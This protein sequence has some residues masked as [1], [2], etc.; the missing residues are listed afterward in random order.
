M[1]TDIGC[2]SGWHQIC[3]FSA[4]QKTSNQSDHYLK[5]LIIITECNADTNSFYEC[6][7]HK[8]T[9]GEKEK[10]VHRCHAHDKMTVDLQLT[11]KLKKNKWI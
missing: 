11:T 4:I 7:G 3:H 2:L 1:K 5:S 8:A 6:E 10:I 9:W